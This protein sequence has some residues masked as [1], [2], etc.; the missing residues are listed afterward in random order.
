MPLHSRLPIPKLEVPHASYLQWFPL[1][2]FRRLTVNAGRMHI[3]SA[4]VTTSSSHLHNVHC[5]RVVPFHMLVSK[6]L[7]Q[8]HPYADGS[9]HRQITMHPRPGSRP[10]YTPQDI[11]QVQRI[12]LKFLPT[13]LADAILDMAEYRPYVDAARTD[14]TMSYSAL[15]GPGQNAQQC[16][17][18]SPKIPSIE[19]NGICVP[20]S[21]K[22]VKF[23]IKA[24]ESAWG[25]PR[26]LLVCLG[27]ALLTRSLVRMI[28][29]IP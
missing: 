24:Y 22:K 29:F 16:F 4:T 27:V 19:R 1:G 23:T 28:F 5:T 3:S 7:P 10:T 20:T 12:L 18:V 15:D 17:M 25:K 8:S 13:D 11:A 14:F 9:Y 26:K 6:D 21:V 2:C